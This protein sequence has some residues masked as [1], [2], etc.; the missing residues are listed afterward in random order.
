ML[1]QVQS[2]DAAQCAAAPQNR[3]L[4]VTVNTYNQDGKQIGTRVVD[5]YHYGTRNWLQNHHWWAM[6][7]GHTVETMVANDAEVDEYLENAKKALA[8]KFAG[9]TA[10]A[11]AA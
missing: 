2:Q 3:N 11:V 4:F 8:Q 10:N 1:T 5:M 6:H 7:N 9:E